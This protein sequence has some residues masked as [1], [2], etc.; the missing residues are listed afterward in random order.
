MAYVYYYLFLVIF[1]LV[2]TLWVGG[3][4]ELDRM[5]LGCSLFIFKPVCAHGMSTSEVGVKD[6]Q[7]FTPR[8]VE[9]PYK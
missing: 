8:L 2:I 9:W 6:F 1:T 5:R 3:Q 4:N 7:M